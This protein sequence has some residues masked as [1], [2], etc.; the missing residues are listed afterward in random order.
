MV[1]QLV[2]A[3][4]FLVSGFGVIHGT[5]P[6]T[7]TQVDLNRYLGRWFEVARLPNPFE[8]IDGT[9][10]M[11]NYSRRPDNLITVENQYT[12]NNVVNKIQGVARVDDPKSNAKLGVSFF[13]I[14]GYRPV[15]GD[16]WILKIGPDYSYSVVGDRDL[17]YAWILSRTPELTSTNMAAAVSVLKR[18]GYDV[19]Q[20][21]YPKN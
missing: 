14:L 3:L 11:A 6:V 5:P 7:E 1:K 17:K 12:R 8:P 13:D 15:W 18:N 21:I 4:V 20:L 16:Y 19:N 9:R 2:L 10:V